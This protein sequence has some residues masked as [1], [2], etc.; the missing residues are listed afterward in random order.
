MASFTTPTVVHFGTVLYVAALLSAPWPSLVPAA[1][2]LGLC[3]LAE[4]AYGAIVVRRLRR[5]IAY[6]L[7]LEDWLW[8]ACVPLVGT[9]TLVVMALL[10]PSSSTPA[11]FGIGAALV[12]LLFL[13]IRNAWDLVTYLAIEQGNHVDEPTEPN[14]R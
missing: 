11:L 10:L 13:G 3:G 9:V 1:V 5:R 6:Q 2:L 7:V 14:E 12:L 8:Y 4:L